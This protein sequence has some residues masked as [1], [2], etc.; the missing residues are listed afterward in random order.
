MLCQN[1]II[2][3]YFS[4]EL[5]INKYSVKHVFVMSNKFIINVITCPFVILVGSEPL[6]KEDVSKHRSQFL[7]YIRNTY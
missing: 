5:T 7:R 6:I 4:H 2:M 3:F 1:N